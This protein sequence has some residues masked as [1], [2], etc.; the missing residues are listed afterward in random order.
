MSGFDSTPA[1]RSPVRHT[2][3]SRARAAELALRQTELDRR[4]EQIVRE[5]IRRF[6]E[7]C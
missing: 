5:A 7:R 1:R 2:P 4:L 6:R 3:L